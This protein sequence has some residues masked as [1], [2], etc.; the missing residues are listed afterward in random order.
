MLTFLIA[1]YILYTLLL[2]ILF[3][4]FTKTMCN[5][6]MQMNQLYQLK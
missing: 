2:S 5:E 1:K 3:V 4:L 6:L